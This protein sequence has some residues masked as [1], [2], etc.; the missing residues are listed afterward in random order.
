MILS[1]GSPLAE[2]SYDYVYEQV[3][4]GVQLASISGGTDLISCFAL[5]NPML[6]VYRGELQCRGLG[7]AVDVWDDAGKPLRGAAGEL[8][9][10]KPFPSMPVAFWNDPDG[11]KY[12]AAYFDFFPGAWRHG[13][14]AE[15]TEHDGL[16]IHGRSD[17]T[18]NPGGVR[19]GTAEIY[20][21][22]EQMPEILESVVVGQDVVS[23]AEKDVRIVLFVRLRAGHT[24]D[25]ALRDR[26]KKSIRAATSPHHVP[27]VIEAVADIPRTISGKIS[28]IAVR[29][30]LH[31]RVVKNTDALAN[32]GALDL[33]RDL[34]ALRL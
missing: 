13:D 18:L 9:C 16:I 7:M 34:P 29:D 12:R 6:P 8:V 4:P 14:W 21:Q 3:K 31:G 28:E 30:V 26:I 15:I 2:H 23:G 19:I 5:G 33:F 1:T 24:L 25:D 22:V 17:A 32:P 11:S 10:T 27:K 20:R